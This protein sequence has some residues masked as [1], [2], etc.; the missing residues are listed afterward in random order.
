MSI[1][2]KHINKFFWEPKKHQVLND[3]SLTTKAGEFLAIHGE[4]GS[5]KS[6]LLYILATL[7]SDYEGSLFLG[8]QNITTSAP[9]ALNKLRNKEIGFV[10]QFHHLLP[11]FSVLQNIMLPA[12]KLGEKSNSQI[13]ED[14][15]ALLEE[16]D[17]KLLA[18]KPSYKLSGGQQQRVAIG[19]AL[20]NSPQVII[21]DEPT[22]S[23]DQKNTANVFQILKEITIYRKKTVIVA[24]HNATIYKNAERSAEMIDGN[25]RL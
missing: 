1:A 3:I 16:M 17:L 4:S 5:G 11:E 24:T 21:A 20:I 15:L 19:R 23:L 2:V 18:H 13:R 14:A 7:D 22:G 8:D 9:K 10:Y 6:T 12:L 25:L